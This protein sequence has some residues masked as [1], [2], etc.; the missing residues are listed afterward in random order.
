MIGSASIRGL[1]FLLAL[2]LTGA[3]AA[4]AESILRRGHHN[5]PASLD[6]AETDGIEEIS[7]ESDLFEGLVRI[8]PQGRMV[9]GVA[10]S[11]DIAPDGLTWTFHLRPHLEWSDGSP[12]TAADFVWT[13]RHALAPKT[14]SP[15]AAILY[16]VTGARDFN[17]GR[18]KDPGKIGVTAPDPDTV[19]I[20]LDQPT[21]YLDGIMA[22]QV[23]FPLKASV[24]EAN[25]TQWTRPGTLV[26]NGAFT[27]EAWTPNQ[28]IVLKKN[29]HYYDAGAV[30]LDGVRWLTIEEDQT[31]LRRYLAGEVDIA[32]V[33]PKQ[34]PR[35]R[36]QLG[37]Q[38]HTDTVLRTTF[39]VLNASRPP[40]DDVRIRQA[41][42][43]SVD[44]PLLA[45]KVNPHGQKPAEGF[46]PP[47]IAGYTRPAPDWLD[48][49]MAE[50]TK[51]AA[52]LLAEAGIGPDHPLK[53]SILYPTDDSD[54]LTLGAIAEMW[55]PLG[56]I[57]TLDNQENRV[58]NGALRNH[59]FEM[60]FT[61]W[62]ADY[63][64]PSN[65]LATFDGR[66]GGLNSGDWRN[67][68]FDALL[69]KAGQTTDP[70]ARMAILAQAEA[71]LNREAPLITIAYETT[72]WLVSPK[73]RGYTANPLDEVVSRN[74]SLVP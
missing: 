8:D 65:F 55:K 21:P 13:L 9:P 74:L 31:S 5:E 6:P 44:R 2:G 60:G 24:V 52:T 40:F 33:P 28:D 36:T 16:P 70:A 46:I 1:A 54:R 11:W 67:G 66:A 18:S 25:G 72:P 61:E 51:R 4:S 17:E 29:P 22:L 49:S 38:L 10:A 15:Y 59:Q 68:A 3:G 7:I 41:L 27:L 50:R 48:Q 58:V 62:I 73:V 64:D 20:A 30:A 37:D 12:L 32:R 34:V 71:L 14:A 57:A 35:I 26:G 43:L 47:G 23:A 56:V 39:L 69:D 19:R 42:A 63:P 45:E 53:V